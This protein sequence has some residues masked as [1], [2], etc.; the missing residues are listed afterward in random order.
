MRYLNQ[1]TNPDHL[2]TITRPYTPVSQNGQKG[3]VDLIIKSYPKPG[4]IMSRHI[5]SL[6]P[7]VDV[8]EMKGPFKKIEYRANMY[9]KMGMIAGGTGITPMLQIIRE[10]LSNPDDR[11]QVSLV[12]ANISEE[13]ILL[14]D[15]LDALAYL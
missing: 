13:D 1:L 14:R 5:Q 6:R 10:V 8:V 15:E 12:F 3:Y 7:G 9:K 2:Q 4:G 11:T